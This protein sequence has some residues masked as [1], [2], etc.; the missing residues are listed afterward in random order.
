MATH[1]TWLVCEFENDRYLGLQA[2][3]TYH[4][5]GEMWHRAL[6][7]SDMLTNKVRA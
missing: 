4:T 5:K 6:P 2:F 1:F 3:I 7:S